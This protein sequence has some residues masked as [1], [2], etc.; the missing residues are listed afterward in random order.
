[1]IAPIILIMAF[2]V[3]NAKLHSGKPP[4]IQAMVWVWA[5]T[6]PMLALAGFTRLLPAIKMARQRWQSPQRPAMDIKKIM[7]AALLVAGG[8][9]GAGIVALPVKTATVGL[10]PSAAG[11]VGGWGYMLLT[12]FLIVDVSEHCGPGAN[13]TTMAA[14]TLGKRWKAVSAALYI[15][16]YCATLTAYIAESATFIGPPVA[17]VLGYGLPPATLSALF[18]LAFGGVIA[19]GSRAVDAV[20][21]TCVLVALAAFGLLL[22]I[23]GS[24]LSWASL[25]YCNWSGAVRT[26]PIMIVAF[27]FHNMIPSL[28]DYLKSAAAV[29][30]ALV[31]GTLIP[32]AMYL[33]WEVLI[34]GSLPPGTRLASVGDLVQMMGGT[35]A[36]PVAINV[37]S[38]FAIIT[39]FLGVGMGCI[40]FV[41][42]LAGRPTE[43]KGESGSFWA[44]V[45]TMA[46]PLCIAC[47]CPKLFVAALEISGMLRLVLFAIIPAMMV[48]A[49]MK[50]EVRKGW[51]AAGVAGIAVV[52]ILVDVAGRLGPVL[53]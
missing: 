41:K 10:L 15:F 28:F 53:A 44:V 18:A 20:N 34:L 12:A 7:G 5:Y 51:I 14:R 32:L 35:G 24:G 29:R 26:V 40:D 19:M 33:L 4:T 37:F 11:L 49:S 22:G 43:G 1:M 50:S 17:V 30:V 36:V 45:A 16:V 27:T 38:L 3:V 39:S 52:I 46:P 48:R 25:T 8:T 6:M 47:L 31:I 13:F 2:L 42:D 23:G 9:V 21:T